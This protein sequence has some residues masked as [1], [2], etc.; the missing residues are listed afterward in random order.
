MGGTRSSESKT[1]ESPIS[2]NTGRSEDVAMTRR[3]RPFGG[4]RAKRTRS[5]CKTAFENLGP[6]GVHSG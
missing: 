6:I 4:R 3:R 2:V 1:S 5:V